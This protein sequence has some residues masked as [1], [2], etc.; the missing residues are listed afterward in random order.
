MSPRLAGLQLATGTLTAIPAGVPRRIDQSTRRAAMLWAP[1]AVLPLGA[2]VTLIGWLGHVLGMPASLIAFFALGALIMGNRALHV[3]GLADTVD[4]LAAG[5]DRQHSLGIMRSGDAGPAG[6]AAIVIVLGIQAAALSTLFDV[7]WGPLAAGVAVC[8]SRVAL[9]MTCCGGVP[10]ARDCGLGADFAG[11]VPKAAAAFAWLLCTG[12]YACVFWISDWPWIA[13][14]VGMCLASLAVGILIRRVTARIGGVA[15]DT[16]GAAI[17][18]TFTVLLAS[19][20]IA[21]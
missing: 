1:V 5:Y 13:A 3:D 20:A 8:L 9:T 16:F 19:A 2:L 14:A 11:C 7:P 21:G 18:V 10:S 12:I 4:G 17:E 15:G 6:V